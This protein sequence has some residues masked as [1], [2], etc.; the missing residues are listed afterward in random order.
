[1]GILQNLI[2]RE[3]EIQTWVRINPVSDEATTTAQQILYQNPD[4]IAFSIMNLG[5]ENVALAPDENVAVDYG[6]L[7]ASNGGYVSMNWK[8][9]YSLVG[10]DWWV[11]CP[12]GT[13]KLLTLEVIGR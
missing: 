9:D 11:L 3:Y 12:T 5:T 2:E 4:R 6:I 8:E 13:S 7:L 10:Y 1:M